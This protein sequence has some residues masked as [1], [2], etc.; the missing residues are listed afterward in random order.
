MSRNDMDM[1]FPTDV[2]AGNLSALVLLLK[3]ASSEV[4]YSTPQHELYEDLNKKYEPYRLS[5]LKELKGQCD[6]LDL[7][8]EY[9][10]YD[11]KSFYTFISEENKVAGVKEGEIDPSHPNML[12]NA[13]IAKVFLEKLFGISFNP[14]KYLETLLKGDKF[15]KY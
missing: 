12:G 7:E 4:V 6:T 8:Y 3:K 15:P 1:K 2:H 9:S 11:Y 14:E 5:A 10:K 13:F